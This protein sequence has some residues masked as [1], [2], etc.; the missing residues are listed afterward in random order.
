[1]MLHMFAIIIGIMLW[2]TMAFAQQ[3]PPLTPQEEAERMALELV[4]IEREHKMC[5]TSLSDVWRR[6]NGLETQVQ[7]LTKEKAALS[8]EV[9][10]AKDTAPAQHS[11]AQ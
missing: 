5:R 3:P 6:A 2:S 4:Y 10:K 7:A 8:E 11:Q 9:K 1:M